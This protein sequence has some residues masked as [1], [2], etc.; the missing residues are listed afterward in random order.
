[1]LVVACALY[2]LWMKYIACDV[3]QTCLRGASLETFCHPAIYNLQRFSYFLISQLCYKQFSSH[4][5][6]SSRE[7]R[8]MFITQVP[9]CTLLNVYSPL[10]LI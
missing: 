1:M 6:I 3:L 5:F 10:L 7:Y 4:T 8:N 2:V 9:I